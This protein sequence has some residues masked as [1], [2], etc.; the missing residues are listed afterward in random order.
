[1]KKHLLWIAVSVALTVQA[2]PEATGLPL[3]N[4]QSSQALAAHLSAS[5]LS[6]YHYKTTALDDALSEKIFDRYLKSLDPERIFFLQSDVDQ[7][8]PV[9][10]RLDDAILNEN[11]DIPFA[12]FNLYAERAVQRYTY[13]RSLLKAGF[14][15]QTK[16]SYEY[17]REKAPWPKSDNEMNDLWRKRVK[18]DW[19]QLK[20]AGKTDKEI[21]ETLDKRYGNFIKRIGKTKSEDVFQAFMNAYTMAVEPH[22][23]YMGPRSAEDFDITMSL[24]LVGI[25][26]L[27]EEKDEMASIKELIP[28]GPAFLSG[29][30]K[31]GDRIVGVAQGD[32]A[33]VDVV[34]WRLDDTVALIRGA[35]DSTVRLDTLPAGVDPDGK[36]KIVTLVRKK[37]A[38]EEQSAKKSIV[39]VGEGASARRIG[40]IDLPVFYED[41][42]GRRKGDPNYKSASRDVAKLLGELKKDKVDAVLIDLRNNGGGSLNEAIELTGLFIDKGPVVQQRDARG[43]INVSRDEDAGTAW[44]GPLGVLV[45]RS[46]ASAS[47]IFAAAIQDYKRGIVIGERS[48]GKGTVQ[49]LLDLDQMARNEKPK[50]GELKLTIAQ[51]FRINGGTTQLKGVT[52]DIALPATADAVEY[53]ETHY[54]NALPWMSIRPADYATV[55]DFTELLPQLQARHDARIA[56]DKD[57]TY[58]QEDIA[59]FDSLKQRKE[60]SLNEADRRK[61]REQREAKAKLRAGRGVADEPVTQAIADEISATGE[62]YADKAEERGDKKRKKA[63]DLWLNEAARIL[64]DEV[65]LV[66]GKAL[67]ANRN[68]ESQ[69]AK[70]TD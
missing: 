64:G 58:L 44:D 3:L 56:K 38:L 33:M 65:D 37:I 36:H 48:F 15:F 45:N 16:E 24:S 69:R 62:T 46:S 14:E 60:I 41:F 25:G 9:R 70:S 20:L 22:T 40:V 1:M 57:F 43:R 67:M 10:T 17:L 54:D 23:N 28:G 7:M 21:A 5:V 4:P 12:I 6:R 63:K 2:A 34:G 26:A 53:G 18:S 29:K 55:G 35:L 66:K 27:L 19:L 11:L 13:A 59:E 39:P 8:A 32:A 42:S 30:L 68:G 47:E 51:F 52:P 61:E 50:L 49:T 31:V